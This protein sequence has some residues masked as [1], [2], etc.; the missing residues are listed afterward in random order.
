MA[1]NVSAL[2]FR[3][4]DFLPG[5]QRILDETGLNPH[6]LELELTE[7][8]LMSSSEYSK[9]MLHKLKD[10]GVRLAVDDFG[11][12]YSS[13]NYLQE[14]PIDVLKIDQSFVRG[15]TEKKG[16]RIIVTAVIGMGTNLT[17]R[18]IAEGIETREQFVFLKAQ[19]CEEGQGHYF[20]PP[21]T[22]AQCTRL[23]AAGIPEGLIKT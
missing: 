9:D 1:V 23:L 16:K 5:I 6:F 3:N 10:I 13:L 15:I 7:G 8:L 4:A 14:F 20:S 22:A 11:T 19:G 2:E 17:H 12:G 18:V 21:L